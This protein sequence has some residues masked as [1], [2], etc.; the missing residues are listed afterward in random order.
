MVE[1]QRWTGSRF[2]RRSIGTRRRWVPAAAVAAGVLLVLASTRLASSRSTASPDTTQPAAVRP[3]EPRLSGNRPWAPFRGRVVSEP[4]S[5]SEAAA[6]PALALRGPSIPRIRYTNG[7]RQLLAGQTLQARSTLAAAAEALNEPGA[8]ND[9]SVACYE[10]ALRYDA[11]E[12]LTDAVTAADRAL[13]L[14]RDLPEALFNR[15]LMIERLGLLTDARKAWSRYLD[16][17]PSSEWAT[18]ARSHLGALPLARPF[19]ADLDDQYD[20]VAA[21]PAFAAA[22]VAQD[23]FGARGI[24][25]LHVLG[26]WATAT[27]RGDE[28]D[29]KRHLGVA[30]ALAPEVTRHGDHTLERAI[31][32]I[33]AA[34]DSTRA[35]LAAAQAD[36][37]TGMTTWQDRRPVEAEPLLRRAAAGFERGGSPVAIPARYFASVTLYERGRHDDAE[38]QVEQLFATTPDDYPAYR[39]FILWQLGICRRS[40]ADWGPAITAFEQSAA[41]FER[42]GEIQNLMVVHCMVAFVY[43]RIGDRE[44]AWAHRA[45]ALRIARGSRAV[46]VYEK[47]TSAIA[48]GA[49]LQ[50]DWQKAS[51]FL[52]LHADLARRQGDE[53]MLSETLFVQAVVRD[54]LGDDAGAR[55]DLAEARLARAGTKD[56][57][58]RASL[59][60]AELRAL[61]MLRETPPARVE[62]LLTQALESRAAEPDPVSLPDLLLQ[63]ARARRIAGD[64][65]G[66]L[67]DVER[68]IADLEANR[69]TLPEGE[70]RWGAF[71]PA[72]ELFDE[73]IDLALE[74][75]DAEAAFRFAERARARS[76]LDSY[77]RSPILDYRRLPAGTLVVEYAAAASRLVI[78]TVDARGA[79]ATTVDVTRETLERE[80]EVFGSALRH[81]RNNDSG[82]ALYRR[83]AEPIAYELRAASTIV[84]V[85]DVVTS[86]VPFNALPHATGVP[87]IQEHA[88]VI[89]ASAAAFAAAAE[90]RTQS[91]APLEALVIAASA[92][93][94]DSAA[95][96]SAGTESRRVG[97]EYVNVTRIEETAAQFDELIRRAAQADVIHFCG[98]AVG[99][100]SG[101][102]PASIV[103]RQN[104]QARRV[105]VKEIAKLRLRRTAIV[106][107]AGCSTARGERRAAEGVSSVAHGFLAAGAASVIATLWPIDDDAAA[108]FFP[109]VHRYLARGMSPAEALR[110][111]QL[112]SIQRGDVPAS[113]WAAVQDIGS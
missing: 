35:T 3:V 61:A 95:L 26:R 28:R 23:P 27:L 30:R 100:D 39:A 93:T 42:M 50:K 55:R 45:E 113:L 106:V 96:A 77:G 48:E 7:V 31:A 101:L 33:D 72:E 13:S 98:H 68:G 36:Y 80:V 53:M 57:G 67:A 9:L 83:L 91:S 40:R 76:L 89:G 15:A 49:L 24:T 85:P 20:R 18:E 87:L 41:L 59:E 60:V 71:H 38:Q 84:F 37:V 90:P 11:P 110:A 10:N 4:I 65:A 6:V 51:S 92:A 79:R 69:N 94:G 19:L 107:L 58:Y 88:V 64:P 111:A 66:A 32:A 2:P 104:G 12:L 86:T 70:I 74:A 34:D 29:A 21:D 17:D 108:R 54:R 82:V 8:W 56:P 105:S 102:E 1:S 52:T 109:R 16:V 73:G 14:D 5:A 103:L 112:E 75:G 63:R 46:M 97:R 47:A 22:V 25:I 44:N 62:A 81:D 99:D 43:D 78:F